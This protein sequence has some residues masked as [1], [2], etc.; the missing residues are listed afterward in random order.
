MNSGVSCDADSPA[1]GNPNFSV[2]ARGL[3][4]LSIAV[5]YAPGKRIFESERKNNY[6]G[7]YYCVGDIGFMEQE[8]HI[9]F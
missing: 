4:V 1:P 8:Y 7:K 3:A 9:F 2:H 6:M 5:L